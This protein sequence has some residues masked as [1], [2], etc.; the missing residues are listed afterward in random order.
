MK[1]KGAFFISYLFC[2]LDMAKRRSGRGG[3][4]SNFDGKDT[5][6]IFE[7]TLYVNDIWCPSLYPQEIH[8]LAKEIYSRTQAWKGVWTQKPHG[9]SRIKCKVIRSLEESWVSEK[10]PGKEAGLIQFT[11]LI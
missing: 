5:S 8:N 3:I 11:K 1:Y 10:A 6:H 4:G 9:S 2:F 7:N